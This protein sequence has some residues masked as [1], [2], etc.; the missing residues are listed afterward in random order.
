M[1]YM[2][3]SL[4][5][6]ATGL[7]VAYI[8]YNLH[9]AKLAQPT[10]TLNAILS[11]RARTPEVK[12][13]AKHMIA[14]LQ[15]VWLL[16]S[17]RRGPSRDQ[18]TSRRAGKPR[19]SWRPLAIAAMSLCIAV[20][21]TSVSAALVAGAGTS[22]YG[23]DAEQAAHLF[24]IAR[25]ASLILSLAMRCFSCLSDSI[26]DVFISRYATPC[27]LVWLI[28]TLPKRFV[29]AFSSFSWLSV[30][31]RCALTVSWTSAILHPIHDLVE[32]GF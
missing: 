7:M 18:T 13:G 21:L 23:T 32:G 27:I 19:M 31:L 22:A 3:I 1:L 28:S 4:A 17:S 16:R 10:K 14:T 12:A 5:F 6:M 20:A 30:E 15:D 26:L 2:A 8:L 11:D 29:I 25:V 9:A 24:S